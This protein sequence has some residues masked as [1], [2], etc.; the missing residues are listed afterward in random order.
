MSTGVPVAGSFSEAAVRVD[1]AVDRDRL[2]RTALTMMRQPSPTC[3]AGA[4]A[5]A[6]AEL[7]KKEGVAVERV[8]GG[9]PDAPAVAVRL[10]SGRPGRCLQFDGH[11]DTVHIPYIP[12]QVD[13]DRL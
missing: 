9:H 8:T 13:G 12:P 1:A 4:A 5:D 2:V 11:L 10:D 3:D 6:L 7:L